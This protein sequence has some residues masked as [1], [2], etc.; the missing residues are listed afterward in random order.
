MI[1]KDNELVVSKTTGIGGGMRYNQGKLRYELTHPKSNIDLVKVLTS[2]AN[3]NSHDFNKQTVELEL[4]G[5]IK[6]R[7]ELFKSGKDYDEYTGLL[8]ISYVAAYIHILNGLPYKNNQ[9]LKNLNLGYELLIPEVTEELVKVLTYGAEK[10]TIHDKETNKVIYDGSMNWR[11]GLSWMSVIASFERHLKDY[12]MGIIND[13]ESGLP[14]LAHAA[15]NIHFLNAFY[16]IFPQG[17]DRPKPYLNI[18]KIGL[19]V[20]GL[21]ADFCKGW[22][23]LYPETPTQ[24]TT[25][26][27]DYLMRE[28]LDKMKKDNTL[29]SFYLN[30]EPLM[31]PEDMPFDPLCYITTR[32]IESSVTEEWIAK[33]GF[34]QVPVYTVP[35]GTS[36]VEVAKKAGVE[37]FVDDCNDN[38]VDFNKNGITCYLYTAS[39]NLKYDVGHLRINSLKELPYF[40]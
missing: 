12:Q 20:D 39:N 1:E 23:K 30:L 40:L 32:P 14:H 15:C 16:Y 28:R 6:E 18:P 4:L 5:L 19:D 38:F 13:L 37:I 24:P 36:K 3:L 33:H 2:L 34:P 11:N 29:D 22:N 27:Y 8:H 31:K 25:W 17:D 7:I 10:Y 26:H 35:I 9:R 21:T